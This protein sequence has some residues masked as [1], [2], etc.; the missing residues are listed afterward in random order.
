[1]FA[2]TLTMTMRYG[3]LDGLVAELESTPSSSRRATLI[4]K[5][6]LSHDAGVIHT[7]APFLASEGRVRAAAI[8]ALVSFGEEARGPMLEILG[9]PWQRERHMGALRVLAAIVMVS[10]AMHP[11]R[12]TIV[13]A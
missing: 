6:A 11:P 9:A 5:L 2:M 13:G 10:T 1:M 8:D 7:I 4:R 12:A 3:L